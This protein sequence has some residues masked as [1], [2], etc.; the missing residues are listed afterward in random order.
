MEPQLVI[1][2][3]TFEQIKT[4]MGASFIN[5]LVEAY[6]VETPLLMARLQQALANE[7]AEAFRT[8]AH[9]IKSSS[10]S[11]GALQFGALARELEALGKEG[12]LADAELKVRELIAG[13]DPV[14]RSLR[15]LC[16]D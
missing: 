3:S 12:R 11:L 5:E 7:E 13:Y 4:D 15:A 16:D 10:C 2:L 14:Q 8:V 9:S 1:D 6:C